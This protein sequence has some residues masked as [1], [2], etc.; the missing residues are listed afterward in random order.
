MAR[1]HARRFKQM[2]EMV[3]VQILTSW[4]NQIHDWDRLE[5]KKKHAKISPYRDPVN[6][7]FRYLFCKVILNLF[8]YI[9]LPRRSSI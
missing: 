7:E 4:E 6:C 5:S 2:S 8:Q 1:K 9:P 3:P